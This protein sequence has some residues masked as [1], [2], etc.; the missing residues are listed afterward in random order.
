[1]SYV[2]TIIGIN[3]KTG[4]KQKLYFPKVYFKKPNNYQIGSAIRRT[5]A[6]KLNTEYKYDW[7]K[8]YKTK[9]EEIEF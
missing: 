2:I 9:I 4:K 6:M 8:G 1:M 3:K 7:N 5:K